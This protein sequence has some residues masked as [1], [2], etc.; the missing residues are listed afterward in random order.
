MGSSTS[1]KK[2]EKAGR[3]PIL[4]QLAYSLELSEFQHLSKVI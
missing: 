1:F 4:I 3:R 2:A